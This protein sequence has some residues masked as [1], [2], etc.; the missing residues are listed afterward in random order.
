MAYRAGD[1]TGSDRRLR[2]KDPTTVRLWISVVFRASPVKPN[3]MH[4]AYDPRT[5]PVA[6]AVEKGNYDLVVLGTENRAVQHR[7]FFG[8][9]NERLIRASRVPVVVVVPNLGRLAVNERSTH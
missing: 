3:V 6:Q 1:R 9:E 4:L 5:S 2:R 8:Y 7:L